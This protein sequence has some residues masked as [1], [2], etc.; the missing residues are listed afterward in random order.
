MEVLIT[1]IMELPSVTLL[2]TV[3]YFML[4]LVSC[5]SLS[6]WDLRSKLKAQEKV[7]TKLVI[8][9]DKVKKAQSKRK[10]LPPKK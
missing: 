10:P 8:A 9:L 6:I 1:Y 5:I 3:S 4:T 2:S 7:I